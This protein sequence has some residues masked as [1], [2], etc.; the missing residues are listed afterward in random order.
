[1]T[2]RTCSKCKRELDI[3]RFNWRNRAR[4]LFESRCK[5][6]RSLVDKEKRK[7]DRRDICKRDGRDICKREYRYEWDKLYQ[8]CSKCWTWL[9]IDR[10]PKDKER[11]FWVRCNCIECYKVKRS[12]SHKKWYVKNKEYSNQSSREYH[13]KNKERINLL[14]KN[15]AD[16]HSKELWFKWYR[17]HAKARYYIKRYSLKPK[18][19]PI[20]WKESNVY[21]HHP[22]YD[23]FDKWSEVVFC[24]NQCHMGIH[25][26]EIE[27]PKSV[28]LLELGILT[29]LP[30]GKSSQ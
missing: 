2:T 3:S 15:R 25:N 16:R 12:E 19:C 30:A 29:K 17:F 20:C 1:M 18:V 22:S 28:N 9:P 4:W 14:I 7:R 10:F 8:K 6:C 21:M 11:P 5:E 23:N 27:C 24:C 13:Q 26:W